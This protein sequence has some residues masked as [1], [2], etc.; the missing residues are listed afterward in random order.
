MDNL[1]LG[2]ANTKAIFFFLVSL[3]KRLECRVS[4]HRVVMIL[5][6]KD[7]DPVKWDDVV[8]NDSD[9][10]ELISVQIGIYGL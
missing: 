3:Q 4:R 9:D 6:Y 2:I 5:Q 10:D 1:I 7:S 8:F